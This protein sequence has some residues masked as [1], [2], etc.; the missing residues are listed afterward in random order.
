MNFHSVLI[1]YSKKTR[2]ITF[3]LLLV[4]HQFLRRLK[5]HAE[6]K[7]WMNQKKRVQEETTVCLCIRQE[8]T[9]P[10]CSL[11]L[12]QR[13]CRERE[14]SRKERK[15][16][17]FRPKFPLTLS[18]ALLTCILSHSH[19]LTF[20]PHKSQTIKALH[21]DFLLFSLIYTAYISNKIRREMDIP[22]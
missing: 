19:S 18:L 9:D 16:F 15:F 11:A 1:N 13:K 8:R 2:L 22:L 5:P 6:A 3:P 17:L 14:R 21:K 4:H 12:Q 20:S 10:F 7:L